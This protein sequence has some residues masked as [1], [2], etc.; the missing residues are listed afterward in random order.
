[1]SMMRH[2]KAVSATFVSGY[3]A[4][5]SPCFWKKKREGTVLIVL[6]Y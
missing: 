2:Q 3:F 1:M 6:P 4:F 5:A